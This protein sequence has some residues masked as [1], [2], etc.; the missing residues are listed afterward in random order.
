VIKTR[1]MQHRMIAWYINNELG[2]ISREAVVASFYGTLK[3]PTSMK[4]KLHRQNSR[5][6]IRQVSPVLLLDISAGN[7]QTALTDESEIIRKQMRTHNRS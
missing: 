2:R 5:P 1:P 7:C 6:F 4:Q 3:I